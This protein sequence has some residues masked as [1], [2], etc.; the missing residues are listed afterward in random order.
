[1]QQLVRVVLKRGLFK[2][3]VIILCETYSYYLNLLKCVGKLRVFIH[4]HLDK[5]TK[6]KIIKLC[7]P[8]KKFM[9]SINHCFHYN[10]YQLLHIYIVT[11]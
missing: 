6:L 11:S 9:D 8:I 2:I 3:T 10:T 5:H 1:M 7:C 4:K